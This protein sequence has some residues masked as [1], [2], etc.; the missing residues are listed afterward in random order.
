MCQIA[1]RPS[2]D[3]E[4]N[5]YSQV[6]DSITIRACVTMTSEEG[7]NKVNTVVYLLRKGAPKIELGRASAQVTPRQMQCPS[8]RLH[9]RM[10]AEIMADSYRART[11]TPTIDA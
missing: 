5:H 3:T 10:V 7:E 1:N 8:F 4:Y 2:P 9:C 6:N 11:L